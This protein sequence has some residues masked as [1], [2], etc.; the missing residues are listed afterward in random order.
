MKHLYFVRHGLSEFNKANVWSGSTDSPLAPEGEEQAKT[1]GRKAKKDGLNIDAIVCSPLTRARQTAEYIAK[2]LGI[3]ADKIIISDLVTER[4]FGELEGNV[5]L[6]KATKYFFDES[7]ID[8][9]EGVEKLADLQKRA[10]E[11]LEFLKSLPQDNI[12]VVGHGAAGRALFRA[13]TGRPATVRSV[14]FNNA[15]IVKFI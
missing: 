5:E 6:V 8:K 1:T 4:S 14:R 2:E 11:A 15:E 9:Y 7:A 10:N 12:L 13:V 3:S